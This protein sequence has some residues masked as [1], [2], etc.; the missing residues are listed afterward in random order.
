MEGP[1]QRRDS[2]WAADYRNSMATVLWRPMTKRPPPQVGEVEEVEEQ[3]GHEWLLQQQA[4][5]ELEVLS[6]WGPLQAWGRSRSMT[7]L[8]PLP[9][10][11]SRAVH[12]HSMTLCSLHQP[13][14]N[15]FVRWWDGVVQAHAM[16]DEW[17]ARS[18]A[19]RR[20]RRDVVGVSQRYERGNALSRHVKIFEE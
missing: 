16:E 5:V 3:R 8:R 1:V 7:P 18:A 20:D 15:R 11:G 6:Q 14:P 10:L 2:L 4:E 9:R 17:L 12:S 19:A 13:R